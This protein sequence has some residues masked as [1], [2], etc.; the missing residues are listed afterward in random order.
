[1]F[2]KSSYSFNVKIDCSVLPFSSEWHYSKS[3]L[4]LCNFGYLLRR[5]DSLRLKDVEIIVHFS[6]QPESFPV[7]FFFQ[8][9]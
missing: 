6:C 2:A 4:A 7:F 3:A 5:P 9:E 1:M 8:A